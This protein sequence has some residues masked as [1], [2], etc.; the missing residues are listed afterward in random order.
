MK[1]PTTTITPAYTHRIGQSRRL[2]PR[3]PR[4]AGVKSGRRRRDKDYEFCS[5]VAA[6]G[7]VDEATWRTR[8]ATSTGPDAVRAE[9]VATR[10][11]PSA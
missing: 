5:A 3:G 4:P 1:V 10:C 6:A 9:L 11:F 2:L 7:L 8:I